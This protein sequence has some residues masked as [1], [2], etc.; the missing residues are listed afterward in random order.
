MPRVGTIQGKQ[1]RD[2]AFWQKPYGQTEQ[3]QLT[4]QVGRDKIGKI[5]GGIILLMMGWL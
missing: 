1:C 2:E 3:L 5:E 4:R